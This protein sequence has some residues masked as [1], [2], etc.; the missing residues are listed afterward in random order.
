MTISNFKLPEP[1]FNK[2]VLQALKNQRSMRSFDGKDLSDQE[3]SEILWAAFGINREEGVQTGK[4]R[5]EAAS[6]LAPSAIFGAIE[7]V[8]LSWI[9]G[10]RR[11]PLKET[12][13]R[14]ADL[15]LQGLAAT[16]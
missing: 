5:S 14:L 10:Y 8:S 3:L 1:D 12:A 13:V 9:L 7:N 2:P 16:S 15:L 6:G 11:Y 4:F